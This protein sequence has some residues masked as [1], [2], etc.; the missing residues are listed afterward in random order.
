MTPSVNKLIII[1]AEIM[2]PKWLLVVLISIAFAYL[3]FSYTNIFM[4]IPSLGEIHKHVFYSMHSF[5]EK[6][7]PR[8]EYHGKNE[9]IPPKLKLFTDLELGKY[10]G[11]NNGKIYLSILGKVFDV[12]N[13]RK[14]YGKGESY[15]GFAGKDAS[16]AF[17]TGDFTVSGLTDDLSD[18]SPNDLADL[19]DWL[20]MYEKDYS[21]RGKLIGRF[22]DSD[23]EPTPYL[24]SIEEK[25][26]K[27]DVEKREIN[28]FKNK[29]PPC[30]VE[31]TPESGSRIWCSKQSG[32]IKR[33]WVG[34]PRKFYEPGSTKH[35][36]ACV[37]TAEDISKG[38]FSEY[39]G[40]QPDSTSCFIKPES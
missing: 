6:Y 9:I 31:W 26:H 13:G 24:K 2:F 3:R 25:I 4:F 38:K 19:R 1:S 23:G 34:V 33:S 39:E 30:N 20:L 18:V 10:T 14:Y 35:R 5:K 7:F 15:H 22:Y 21:Y 29:Y 27:I 37:N 40:C 36:C 28:S 12:T 16:K 32:G 17:I 11:E 8:N